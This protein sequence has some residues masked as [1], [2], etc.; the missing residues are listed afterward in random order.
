MYGKKDRDYEREFEEDFIKQHVGDKVYRTIVK[1]LSGSKDPKKR[2][3]KI[4]LTAE[5]L[6]NF[7]F[8]LS[9]GHT[10]KDSAIYA[11]IP[12]NTRQK[13]MAGSETFQRVASLAKDN[14]SIQARIGLAQ[15]I[16]GRKPAYWGFKH[17]ITNEVIYI[18]MPEV[19]SNVR[20]AMWYLDQV[21]YFEKL[22]KAKGEPL[23][24]APRN[25]EEARLLEELLKRHH[26]YVVRREEQE[27]S[28]SDKS[29]TIKEHHN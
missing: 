29:D 22:N 27:E 10:Y 24:G 4:E 17:P 26:D 18:L 12:E 11:H 25:E 13:Y 19:R 9:L 8:Y 3:R 28:E 2:G 1:E 14:L 6:H 21:K 7:L 23:S 16:C 15:A 5:K 20:A